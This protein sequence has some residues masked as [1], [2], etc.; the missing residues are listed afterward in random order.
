MEVTGKLTFIDE[1][2]SYGS[3]DFRKREVVLTTEEQYP[4]P[5]L[6]EFIKDKCDI[7]NSYKVGDKVS[8]SINLRGRE[9]ENAEG[10]KK[11]FNSVQGW[12]INRMSETEDTVASV[13]VEQDNDLPF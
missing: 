9:W 11:Y 1:T 12:R 2:K 3:N 5:L 10:E 4:Q 6:I 7:L 8:I 13:S